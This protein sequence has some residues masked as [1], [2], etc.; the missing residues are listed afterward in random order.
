MATLINIQHADIVRHRDGK[1]YRVSEVRRNE[2]DAI[3]HITIAR[4]EH[5]VVFG[6]TPEQAREQGFAFGTEPF[7]SNGRPISHY[8]IPA[9]VETAERAFV[10]IE[11]GDLGMRNTVQFAISAGN[12][13]TRLQHSLIAEQARF[14][15]AQDE[16]RTFREEVRAEI[17]EAQKK[18]DL[19]REGTNAVLEN[20]GLKKI[21]PTWS[22]E[23]TRDSDGA[24]IATITGVEADTS[25]DAEREVRDSFTVNAT[26]KA[27]TYGYE[28]DGEGEAD[29][30]SE[31]YEED[32]LS[33]DDDEYADNHKNDLSF[34]ATEE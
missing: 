9:A 11:V 13:V 32:D 34:S 16:L 6:G 5:G 25:D 29:F 27:V 26:V 31:E 17:V 10:G 2:S 19:C 12:E 20:L 7:Y 8:D 1:T 33:D 14:R 22:V 30:D 24:T 28:Y 15:S 18:H 21:T 3:V 4:E 23:V